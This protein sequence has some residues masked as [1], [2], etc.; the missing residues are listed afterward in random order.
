MWGDAAGYYVYSPMWFIYGNNAENFPKGIIEAIGNGFQPDSVSGKIK[1]KYTSGVAIFQA[2]FFLA[3]HLVALLTSPPSDGSP[4]TSPG[5]SQTY[6]YSI[7]V[8]GAVYACLGMFFLCSFLTLYFKPLVSLVTCIGILFG[9]NLYYY[10]IGPSGMSHVYSFFVFSA[11]LYHSTVFFKSM[12]FKSAIIFGLLCGM[13]ILLRPTNI[14]FITFVVFFN[15]EGGNLFSNLISLLKKPLIVLTILLATVSI[16]IPQMLYWYETTGHLITY[17]YGEEGFTNWK[18]PEL[19]KI[20]F[21][22][23][24][25]LFSYT[26]LLILSI[27]G[28][29]LLILKKKQAGFTLGFFF[30]FISYVFASWW[31]W[32]YGCALGSRPFVEYYA[33]MAI[34]LA[35]F[36]GN[37]KSKG[38]IIATTLFMI[39]C[40]WINLDITYYYDGCFYGGEWDWKAYFEL[41]KD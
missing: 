25:G 5:F 23:L 41:L 38:G 10:A 36:L 9:S 16:W 19:I 13:A 20:W 29:V 28:I 7:I 11:L 17:S 4:L 2:P 24:N 1:N 37:L 27:T 30:L 34:P 26:P 15:W 39:A 8:S 14:I 33:L 6:Y 21:S 35:S 22:S 40:I 18:K 32:T 31:I 3:S 12:T